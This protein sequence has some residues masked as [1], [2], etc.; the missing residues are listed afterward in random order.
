MM[1]KKA[2]WE[3]SVRATELLKRHGVPIVSAF[4]MV[5]VP[6]G[7]RIAIPNWTIDTEAP[8]PERPWR[9]PGL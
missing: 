1:R 9:Y 5:F 3:D 2:V 4:R 8:Q 7:D 6:A